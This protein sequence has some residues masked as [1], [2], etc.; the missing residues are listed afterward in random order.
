ML[1]CKGS[2]VRECGVWRQPWTS[3]EAWT[4]CTRCLSRSSTRTLY[5]SKRSAEV[6]QRSEL[7]LKGVVIPA[8]AADGRFPEYDE[9]TRKQTRLAIR[10]SCEASS[11]VASSEGA[12]RLKYYPQSERK[13]CAV[14]NV[15]SSRTARKLIQ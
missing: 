6:V 11:S 14:R 7:A 2:F 3:R 9:R 15:R 13:Y 8:T 10:A 4:L 1:A 12:S 5:P